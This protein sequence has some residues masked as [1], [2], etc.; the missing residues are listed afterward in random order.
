MDSVYTAREIK[1]SIDTA[2]QASM[3]ANDR[4]KWNILLDVQ[5]LLYEEFNIAGE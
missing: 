3:L 1:Y 2:I 4:D 5:R